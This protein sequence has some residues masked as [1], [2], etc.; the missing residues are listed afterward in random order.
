MRRI[1]C[2]LIRD[3][4]AQ[5]V[6]KANITVDKSVTDSFETSLKTETNPLARELLSQLME[7]Y[8]I[9]RE[10]N[11]PIC[12]D[13]GCVAVFVEIGQ[14]V[15]LTGGYIGDMVQEGI[16]IGY[17]EGY[18]RNSM[19]KDPFIREN[20]G[21]NT[22]AM[23]HYDIVPGDKL[24]VTV[25]PKGAG[26][27]NMCRISMLK[28]TEGADAVKKFVLDTIYSAGPNPCPP[29]FIGVGIGGSF[30]K[31]AYLA[32][33]ALTLPFY[34]RSLQPHI[35]S[36]EDDLLKSINEL[37]VGPQG[38]GGATTAL[39]LRV[40]T[41]PTH[42]ASLPVAVNLSCHALRIETVEF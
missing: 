15:C 10:E 29:L 33:K 34:E 9:A 13:T 40:L 5:M 17:R 42:I 21:D 11:L 22:P 36:L 3:Q 26:C 19:V 27:E 12:Q 41:Y 2:G 8:K 37:D 4:I 30:E 35:S 1:D 39:G 32:K 38:M 14:D 28:P 20:T 7:N 25:L 31:A 18:L 24:K 23:I 6:V 16:R